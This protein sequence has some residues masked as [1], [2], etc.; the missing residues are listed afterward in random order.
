MVANSEE[1]LVFSPRSFL[2]LIEEDILNYPPVVIS[3]FGYLQELLL[4]STIFNRVDG[5]SKKTNSSGIETPYEPQG[6]IDWLQSTSIVKWTLVVLVVTLL[7]SFIL[8]IV[9]FGYST[10]VKPKNQNTQANQEKSQEVPLETSEDGKTRD[11][12]RLA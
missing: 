4:N 2:S 7:I 5:P 1:S 9:Y 6:L 11:S 10:A 12:F 8:A 3:S